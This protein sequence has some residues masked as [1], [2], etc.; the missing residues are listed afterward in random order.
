MLPMSASAISDV[1]AIVAV[2]ACCDAEAVARGQAAVTG[3]GGAEGCKGSCCCASDAA[4]GTQ[5]SLSLSASAL[6]L[7]EGEGSGD[8]RTAPVDLAGGGPLG[9][10]R[11]RPLRSPRCRNVAELWWPAGGG[12]LRDVVHI[13]Q[14]STKV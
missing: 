4:R 7:G 5:H 1:I 10:L 12:V 8:A 9:P 6:S 11:C 2:V 14:D 3:I 13:E